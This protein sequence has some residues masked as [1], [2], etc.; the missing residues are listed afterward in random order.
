MS[1]KQTADSPWYGRSVN[2]PSS[3]GCSRGSGG[4]NVRTIM[5]RGAYEDYYR[6]AG[7]RVWTHRRA[8]N[9]DVGALGR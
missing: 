7:Y 1:W 8:L 3:Y 2:H 9:Q 4:V 5:Y 6:G